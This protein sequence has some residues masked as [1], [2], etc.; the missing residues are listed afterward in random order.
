[1]G[2]SLKDVFM[3]KLRDLL[4]ESSKDFI[5]VRSSFALSCE[6]WR[7]KLRLSIYLL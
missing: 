3:V 7:G 2:M 4:G 6:L 1:M 5:V